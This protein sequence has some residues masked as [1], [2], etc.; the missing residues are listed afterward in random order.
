L[1]IFNSERWAD[2]NSS[3]PSSTIFHRI[4]ALHDE[5]ASCCETP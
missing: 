3:V 4:D 1:S 2:P 5:S